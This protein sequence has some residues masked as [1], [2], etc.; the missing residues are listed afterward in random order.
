MCDMVYK[1]GYFVKCNMLVRNVDGL[2]SLS[3]LLMALVHTVHWRRK[4]NFRVITANITKLM[5]RN[6]LVNPV[7]DLQ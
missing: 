2:I 5:M 6:V 1:N 3:V 7:A 4:L